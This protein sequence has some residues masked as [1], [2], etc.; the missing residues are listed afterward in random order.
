MRR[1]ITVNLGGNAFQLD[2]DAYERLRAYL[3]LSES[4]LAANPDRAEIIG[5]LERAV[6]DRILA[7][8]TAST[9]VVV[10]DAQMSQ[11]LSTVG[12]VEHASAA[13]DPVNAASPPPS[14]APPWERRREGDSDYTRLP[15]F[16]LCLLFGWLGIHRFFI[17]KIGTGILMLLT[18]G[19]LGIWIVIDLILIL[20]GEFKDPEGR[21]V[22]RWT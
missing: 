18:L 14:S 3:S 13:A 11:T 12:A 8:R 20:L 10:S 17:G 21:K 1:V 16:L 15:I 2:E 22:V 4:R 6:A 7:N 5:D 9:S 19:G